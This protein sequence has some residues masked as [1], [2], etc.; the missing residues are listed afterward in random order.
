MPRSICWTSPTEQFADARRELVADLGAL[1][2]AHA[3][4]DALLG[5]LHGGAA[6]LREID[7]HFHDVADLEF[8]IVESCFLE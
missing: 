1:A 3:L 6:E 2:F 8:R 5:G 7:R 4:D